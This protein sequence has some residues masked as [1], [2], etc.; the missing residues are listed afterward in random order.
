MT[1]ALEGGEWSAACPGRTSPPGKTRYSF[2]RQLGGPEGWSGRAE[3]LIPTGILSRT[4]QPVTQLL[5]RLSY[6]AHLALIN[7]TII[8]STKQFRLKNTI[9]TCVNSSKTACVNNRY[10]L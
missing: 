1:A 4:A 5:Y 8:L 7:N 6:P 9:V 2:Y 10:T 3:N